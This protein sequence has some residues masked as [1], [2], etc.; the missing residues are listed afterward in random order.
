MLTRY[1]IFGCFLLSV[2]VLSAG[3]VL[4]RVV[5]KVNDQVLLQSDLDDE[6]R[7]EC[8]IAHRSLQEVTPGDRKAALD[9]L[10]DQELLRQ[11]MRVGEIRSAGPEEVEKQVAEMRTDYAQNH[12][13]ESWSVA[14][15]RYNISEDSVRAHIRMQFDQLRLVDARLRPSIQIDAADVDNYYK[16]QLLPELIRSG[17][18]QVT[19]SEATGKIRELLTQQKMNQSLISWLEALHSQAVIRVIAPNASQAQGEGQ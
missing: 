16:Q 13:Q 9:R 18:Q 7:Y 14:L 11:Q 15:S 10:I 2:V 17:A 8:F 12:P 1:L 6:I 4:D 19:L 3:E 5:A